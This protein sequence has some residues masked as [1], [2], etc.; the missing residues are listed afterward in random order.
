[1]TGLCH[2]GPTCWCT[3]RTWIPPHT[4]N[5]TM[6][7]RMLFQK[8]S[9]QSL[10]P[11]PLVRPL[12][13]EDFGFKLFNR[14]TCH[15]NQWRPAW[16]SVPVPRRLVNYCTV[17][18]IGY[19]DRY[20][21]VCVHNDANAKGPMIFIEQNPQSLEDVKEVVEEGSNQETR[22]TWRLQ[23]RSSYSHRLIRRRFFQGFFGSPLTSLRGRNRWR[24]RQVWMLDLQ[25]DR[26]LEQK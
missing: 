7:S 18:Q 14:N 15:S 24:M 20:F 8:N 17:H 2:G 3:M 1:M 16:P 19:I 12:D 26:R 11:T 23:Q 6:C 9:N 5:S 4:A 13:N 25:L 22:I 21:L 10:S